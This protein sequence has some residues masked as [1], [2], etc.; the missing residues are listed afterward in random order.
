MQV[1]L[2]SEHGHHDEG[3]QVDALAQHPEVVA[4][5]HV[6]VEEVQHLASH[7][8]GK[9]QRERDQD[10]TVFTNTP[11]VTLRTDGLSGYGVGLPAD[12]FLGSDI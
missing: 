6:H 4:T 3:V 7:L 9:R 12:W 5:Q 8:M 11:T 10:L 1:L 2:L